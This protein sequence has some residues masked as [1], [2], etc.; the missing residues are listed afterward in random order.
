MNSSYQR[1][2]IVSVMVLCLT[3]TT[4][5]PPS[6]LPGHRG[7]LLCHISPVACKRD[8]SNENEVKEI[9]SMIT[10]ADYLQICISTGKS[11]DNCL[12][13]PFNHGLIK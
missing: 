8:L 5:H 11:F 9:P 2:F 6:R 10:I 4:A 1:L 7:F 13:H 12:Q 3:F